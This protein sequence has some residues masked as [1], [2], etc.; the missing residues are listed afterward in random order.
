MVY[1][2]GIALG[3]RRY[4]ASHFFHNGLCSSDS[5]STNFSCVSS[6][7]FFLNAYT[8][9]F[10]GLRFKRTQTR[11]PDDSSEVGTNGRGQVFYTTTAPLEP[12]LTT[13]WR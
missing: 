2:S 9:Q 4:K 3:L 6:P 11:K 10:D 13:G 5:D 8:V 1:D 12:H 7:M